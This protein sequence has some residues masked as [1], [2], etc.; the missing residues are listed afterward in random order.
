MILMVSWLLYTRDSLRELYYNMRTVP[1]VNI[2]ENCG[3]HE[4]Q[5][6]AL[7]HN[8]INGVD[9][10][11]PHLGSLLLSYVRISGACLENICP[12][13]EN[14]D[15]AISDNHITLELRSA[16]LKDVSMDVICMDK[17]IL[18]RLH[19]KDCTFKMF[20]LLGKVV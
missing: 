13:L 14:L 17:V 2:L 3:R 9:Q 10:K 4:L 11:F 18:E 15:I 20:L 19:L 5:V 16:C 12:K 7:A 1:T 6:L 8:S